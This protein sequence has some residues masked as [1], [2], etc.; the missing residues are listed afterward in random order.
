MLGMQP[1]KNSDHVLCFCVTACKQHV[2]NKP[3]C[4]VCA[5]H[6]LRYCAI[7]AHVLPT[8]MCVIVIHGIVLCM[9]CM[10]KTSFKPLVSS[11]AIVCWHGKPYVY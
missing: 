3:A 7:T 11:C 5:N 2:N 10:A 8:I 4:N 9:C 6:T 1:M